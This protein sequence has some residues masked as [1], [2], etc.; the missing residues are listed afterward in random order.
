MEEV[1][2]FQNNTVIVT[3]SRFIVESKVYKI[4]EISSVKVGVKKNYT[5]TKIIIMV[6][7]FLLMFFKGGRIAGMAIFS[8]SFFLLYLS[9]DKFCVKIRTGDSETNGL[10]S[11]D[12]QYIE[13]VVKAINIAMEAQYLQAFPL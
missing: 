11:K 13:Q 1:S 2:F 8:I 3:Q 10:V 6:I 12:K 9:Q 4:K 7:G 5:R